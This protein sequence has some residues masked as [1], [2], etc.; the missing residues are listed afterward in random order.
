VLLLPGFPPDRGVR[1]AFGALNWTSVART[2][3]PVG[4]EVSPCWPTAPRPTLLQFPASPS[5][6]PAWR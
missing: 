1:E 4:I 5:A 3:A 6:S 2:L